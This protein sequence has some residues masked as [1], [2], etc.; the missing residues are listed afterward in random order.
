MSEETI[1]QEATRNVQQRQLTYP[2]V[3]EAPTE[4]S[5]EARGAE[6]AVVAPV[7]TE[8]VMCKGAEREE[9]V[10]S[11]TPI[12]E[13]TQLV[14]SEKQEKDIMNNIP[15]EDVKREN[16]CKEDTESSPAD[17]MNDK[18]SA[19]DP[20]STP[21]SA[22]K[23]QPEQQ[24]EEAE[25][26]HVLSLPQ[27]ALHAIASFL[28][29]TEWCEFGLMNQA[30]LSVCREI[31]RRVR[32]H[33]FKCATEIAT[34]WK[35]GH[36]AD[37]KELASLYIQEGVPV[38][39]RSLGFSH[40]ALLWKMRVEGRVL[41]CAAAEKE[42]K[43][44]VD[45]FY[46]TRSEFRTN[47]G[48][49]PNM[50]YLE[51]K[52]LFW[53]QKDDSNGDEGSVVTPPARN[54]AVAGR[55]S[56]IRSPMHS[57]VESR[58][59]AAATP[60]NS[61]DVL[62]THTKKLELNIHQHLL[63]QH[64][65]RRAILQELD[66]RTHQIT[67]PVSLSAD[68]YHPLR[69]RITSRGR[70]RTLTE[71]APS[72]P[73]EAAVLGQHQE[74]PRSRTAI[75]DDLVEP[76]STPQQQQCSPFTDH[77]VLD[78][79]DLEVYSAE[80]IPSYKQNSLHSVEM[81]LRSQIDLY[82]RRLEKFLKRGDHDGFEECILDFWDEV[83]PATAGFQYFDRH[84]AV[85]RISRLQ[86]FLTKPCPKA[87]STM[88]CE[89]E[90][91]KTTSRGK[92]VNMKGR[93]FPTYEYRLFIRNRPHNPTAETAAMEDNEFVRRDTVLMVAKNRGRK[94]TEA[95]GIVTMSS[96]KKGSNNYFLQMPDQIDV[97]EHFIKVNS[98][99]EESGRMV[100]NG[101]SHS[102]LLSSNETTSGAPLGR[103]QSNFIGTEFQIYVPRLGKRPFQRTFHSPSDDE[104][105]YDSGNSIDN[106]SASRRS[107]FGRLSL[108][109][110]TTS[111]DVVVEEGS[112]RNRTSMIRATSSPDV[113][114]PARPGRAN[115][116][117]IAHTPDKQQQQQQQRM[118]MCEEEDGCIT[119]TANLLGS[120][121]RIMD[122]CIPN[123]GGD[124]VVGAKWKCHLE[125]CCEQEEADMLSCF[126]Q[127]LQELEAQTQ[128]QNAAPDGDGDG[129]IADPVEDFGLLALQ[130]RPPW[131]N[132]ELGSFV[133]NFGG[134]VSVASVKNFQLCARD[135]QDAILLQFGRIQ[136]RHS[137]TMDFR[138]P[139]SAVQAFSIA[140]SSLQSK[141]S[142]G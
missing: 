19:N 46:L 133:L 40:Q 48:I 52:S 123:V 76:I 47:E 49:V 9:S 24:K 137:F 62:P 16:T 88:Q 104:L 116:R 43:P 90:R 91:I 98:E 85:P 67:P 11:S 2:A 136:G 108:R 23:Q 51:L 41:E 29:P 83:F 118:V 21:T 74:P 96:V 33:G 31:V 18:E 129:N 95:S 112:M 56:P 17:D 42:V 77:S 138:H 105:D 139:L 114:Q 107:R 22:D 141:I 100:P 128:E 53:M 124:G 8:M 6:D 94:H 99:R 34:A 59:Q 87:V 109:R 64:L 60:T 142:F 54:A 84:T 38:Y 121:P 26:P 7:N 73:S 57:L 28:T 131:W 115:R 89:I 39:P 3:D 126:R 82:Q 81:T 110:S 12:L 102:S 79:L 61:H 127:L 125:S 120:R 101:A 111:S 5:V 4:V 117:A 68:F 13:T 92:G 75:D 69:K 30:S 63:D 93:L 45:P 65:K 122:V 15:V 37:A 130:N 86:E 78:L 25:T 32:M 50:T 55:T 58:A 10:S 44:D 72:P 140:I 119:Y 1:Q 20:S 80:A 132:I 36:F 66:E 113:A 134:R 135:N 14:S 70:L 27:D 103:L 35:L 106:N 71:E 97:D